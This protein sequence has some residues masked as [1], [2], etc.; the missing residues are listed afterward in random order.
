MSGIVNALILIQMPAFI[1]KRSDIYRMF[2]Q[3]PFALQLTCLGVIGV[4]WRGKEEGG[5]QW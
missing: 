5:T 1:T 3:I 2:T 4:L